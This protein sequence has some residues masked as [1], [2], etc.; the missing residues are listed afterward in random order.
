MPD[1]PIAA[2]SEMEPNFDWDQ[3][4]LILNNSCLETINQ[5]DIKHQ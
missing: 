2:A 1:C 5:I 3:I 4:Y